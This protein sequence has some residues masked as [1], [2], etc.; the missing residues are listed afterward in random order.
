MPDYYDSLEIRSADERE[1]DQF[2]ELAGLL[3]HARN[4]ASAYTE[5]LEGVDIA[6][7]RDRTALASL[8]ITRK[9][10]LV[11]RQTSAPPFGGFAA[12]PVAELSRVFASP[13]PIFEPEAGRRDYWRMARAM[14]AAGLRRGALVHNAFS[15][16]FTP[17]GSMFESGALALGCPVFAAG[18]G[19]TEL[20]VEAMA[21]LR[22]NAYV[23]TPSF[24]NIIIEKAAELGRDIS[25]VRHALVGGEA[26]PPSLREK[27]NATDVSVLQGYGTADV[28]S[29]AYESEAMEGMIIDEGVILEIVQPGSGVPVTVGEV[30]EVVVTPLNPDY[31]LIRFATG[32]LSAVMQGTSPCGRTNARIKG[33]MGRADQTTKV[34]GMFVHPHQV[35]EVLRRHPEVVRG[36][37]VVD[38]VDNQDLMTLSCELSGPTPEGLVAAIVASLREVCKL[39]GEVDIVP[40][41]T[42]A[43]DGKIIDD[44]RTYE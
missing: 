15:Y 29:I 16:H 1:Q 10:D 40:A 28:G 18:V 23:G 2:S 39:R 4:N 31:P 6:A 37:L 34:K 13:G 14:Y 5:L 41:G 38:S 8:P 20:Q 43:N 42:L 44:V 33:W 19:Q 27:I 30:G 17:A 32:D 21:T 7:V 25:S 22:P 26:L 12:T 9:S 24:L 3:Q 11:A 35:A 36:R